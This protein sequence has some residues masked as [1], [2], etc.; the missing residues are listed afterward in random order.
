[1]LAVLLSSEMN[2][3]Y[4]EAKEQR[5]ASASEFGTVILEQCFTQFNCATGIL[6]RLYGNFNNAVY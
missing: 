5:A 6:T 2:S 3:Y 4:S 1:M